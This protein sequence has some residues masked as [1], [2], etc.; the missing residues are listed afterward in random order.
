MHAQVF[1]HLLVCLAKPR[2]F[3]EAFRS[4]AW[5][6][7]NIHLLLN[8]CCLNFDIKRVA[9]ILISKGTHTSSWMWALDRGQ[10]TGKYP[11]AQK[12]ENCVLLWLALQAQELANS[13][14]TFWH[15]KFLQCQYKHALRLR[16]GSLLSSCLRVCSHCNI[17]C[18]SWLLPAHRLWDASSANCTSTLEPREEK[19]EYVASVLF[20]LDGALV[21]SH[22]DDGNI[23]WV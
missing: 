19:N 17:C 15:L 22:Y 3:A 12:L 8:C 11:N 20:S 16:Q 2:Y 6:P 4:W 10:S 13:L 1:G 18:V 14:S 23:R 21:F 7:A 5:I 9:W